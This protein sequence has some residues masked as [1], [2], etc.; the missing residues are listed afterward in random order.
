M[1]AYDSTHSTVRPR[2]SRFAILTLCAALSG[3]PAL[4]GFTV[5]RLRDA[6]LLIFVQP[7]VFILSIVSFVRIYF[8]RG[9][10]KGYVLTLLAFLASLSFTVLLVYFLL[11]VPLD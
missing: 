2:I 3:L 7:V 6:S 11:N 9:K 8:S 1:N 4:L 10:L 5:F